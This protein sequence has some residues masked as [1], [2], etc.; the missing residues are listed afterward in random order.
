MA[1]SLIDAGPIEFHQRSMS[2]DRSRQGG[3]FARF[4]LVP[5]RTVT[6]FHLDTVVH[7]ASFGAGSVGVVGCGIVV[8]DTVRLAHWRV[9]DGVATRSNEIGNLAE[10]VLELRASAQRT[11][12]ESN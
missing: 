3:I 4:A 1:K 5:H 2:D 7:E 10:T 11:D 12:G 8:C 9:A 6:H